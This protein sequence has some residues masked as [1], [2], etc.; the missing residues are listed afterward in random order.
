MKRF[1]C[2]QLLVAA[3]LA[4][5]SVPLSSKTNQA[6]FQTGALTPNSDASSVIEKSVIDTNNDDYGG[7]Q[8]SSQFDAHFAAVG[9]LD[10]SETILHDDSF[11]DGSKI[12]IRHR[13]LNSGDTDEW[14]CAKKAVNNCDANN[15]V[16][17]S[18]LI[19]ISC[20]GLVVN[21]PDTIVDVISRDDLPNTDGCLD[22]LD[23]VLL[24]VANSLVRSVKTAG[25]TRD[26]AMQ[27]VVA[28][29]GI[30]GR[31]NNHKM[32]KTKDYIRKYLDRALSKLQQPQKSDAKISDCSP[33]K[34]DVDVI[35][36]LGSAVDAAMQMAGRLLPTKSLDGSSCQQLR[37][38]RDKLELIDDEAI[39]VSKNSDDI[40]ITDSAYFR[41]K[42]EVAMTTVLST[43]EDDLYEIEKKMDDAMIDG[44]EGNVPTPEFASDANALLSKVSEAYLDILS[45]ADTLTDADRE[46]VTNMR[47]EALKHV[48]G[49]GLHR[50]HRLHLQNLRDHF[51]R[52]YEQILV[53]TSAMDF[54]EI[55]RDANA[56]ARDLQR[57]DGAKKAE[58]GFLNAAFLS[59]PAMCHDPQIELGDLY[60][61]TDALRGLLEDMYEATLSRGMEEEEWNDVMDI[62]AEEAGLNHGN[63]DVDSTHA[64]TRVGLRELIKIVKNKKASRGPAKWYERLAAK[65]LVIGV[66]YVQGWIVL[67]TL[68]REARRRDLTM[69]KF[70]LF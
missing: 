42:A 41:Y 25:S 65:A 43:A 3:A 17:L 18:S 23:D 13:L 49:T 60:S 44:G 40:L 61:C 11:C 34:C 53:K 22:I 64:K 37:I 21:L 9:I 5:S 12:L 39:I 35:A 26:S 19:G 27:I 14:W 4:E 51:G 70:P 48:A 31:S 16:V 20:D 59:I 50:L 28:F 15:L 8:K 2:T 7:V 38:I 30:E 32:N 67:Q 29:Q 55:D 33:N 24:S 45:E 47:I 62:S 66:N 46:W 54:K 58:E 57:R 1:R 6:S 63:N 56:Q 52:I 36:S 69:P 68:R 10:L